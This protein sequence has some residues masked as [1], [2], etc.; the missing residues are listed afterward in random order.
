MLETEVFHKVGRIVLIKRDH[1]RKDTWN[2]S[3]QVMLF[4]EGTS[5]RGN[6]ESNGKRKGE[7]EG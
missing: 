1:L 6:R 5:E 3:E 4:Q 7:G 2:R